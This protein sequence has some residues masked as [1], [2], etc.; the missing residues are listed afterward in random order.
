M[1]DLFRELGQLPRRREHAYLG[2]SQT[3]VDSTSHPN[4]LG[5]IRV[6]FIPKVLSSLLLVFEQEGVLEGVAAACMSAYQ[7]WSHAIARTP[8]GDEQRLW[9]ALRVPA[10]VSISFGVSTC[11]L[12][13]LEVFIILESK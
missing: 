3:S 11:L 13:V 5:V 7:L 4:T 6:S 1:P 9:R 2:I 12:A 8:E 10:T